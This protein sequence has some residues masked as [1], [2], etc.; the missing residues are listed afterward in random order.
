LPF[1]IPPWNISS[2]SPRIAASCSN[3]RKGHRPKRWLFSRLVNA[4]KQSCWQRDV[5]SKK[6]RPRLRKRLPG[7]VRIMQ[8]LV[9]A[10]WLAPWGSH[11]QALVI[12]LRWVLWRS[13]PRARA[14][15]KSLLSPRGE[16]LA[17]PLLSVIDL[18]PAKHGL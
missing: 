9:V 1:K 2:K 12:L 5:E 7:T 10:L 3:Q 18:S 15:P 4:R 11:P 6:K 17:G 8:L 14:K 16:L 13:H